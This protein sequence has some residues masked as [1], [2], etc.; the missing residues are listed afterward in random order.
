MPEMPPSAKATLTSLP[1]RLA[2]RRIILPWILR[3]VEP[4]GEGLEIGAGVGAMTAQLLSLYPRFRMVATDTD[5]ELV[6]MAEQVLSS[7]GKRAS[8]Q[9]ADASALPFPDGRFDLVLSAAMLHHVIE[10]DRALAEA[11]RVLRPGGKLVGYD[12]ANTPP[13]RLARV[14]ERRGTTLLRPDQLQTALGR[15]GLTDLQTST[16]LAGTVMRFSARRPAALT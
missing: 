12:L 2:A 7:F 1:Y 8:V 13:A 11:V 3:G 4:T 16:A 9:R 6:G 15:L 14:G 10:W 5:T